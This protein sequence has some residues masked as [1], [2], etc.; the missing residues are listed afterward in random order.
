MATARTVPNPAAAIVQQSIGPMKAALAQ[1]A[2]VRRMMA[3]AGVGGATAGQRIARGFTAARDAAT[4]AATAT[5]NFLKGAAPRDAQGRFLARPK[6]LEGLSSMGGS[7]RDGIAQSLGQGLTSGLGGL[8]QAGASYAAKM[9][10]FKENTL[11][12]FKYITGSQSE[13][14]ALLTRADELARSMG[15]KTSDVAGSLRELMQGGFDEST[16]MALTAGMADLKAMNP[17]AN[18]EAIAAQIA[19]MKGSGKVL[20]EDLKPILNAGLNDDKFYEVLREQ[21]GE[22]DQ[23]KLKKMMSSGKVTADQGITAILETMRRQG[24]GGALGQ[25][26]ADRA[27]TTTGG[28]VDNAIG[29]FERLVTAVNSSPVG[30]MVAGLVN[31]VAQALDPTAG[32]AKILDVLNGVMSAVAMLRPYL[33]GIGAG[34]VKGFGDAFSTVREVMDLMGMLKGSSPDKDLVAGFT[35][36]AT[37]AGYVVVGIGVVIGAVAG[38]VNLI[39]S[40]FVTL[41]ENMRMIGTAITEGISAGIDSAKSGL[42]AKLTG[43]AEL[44]PASV[45]SLLGIHSPSRVF[46]ELGGYT[47]EGL[48][49]GIDQGAPMAQ[50][51]MVQAAQPPPAR[52]LPPPRFALPSAGAAASGAT[53]PGAAPS[54]TIE[55]LH[56]NVGP[57]KDMA[58]LLAKA[59]PQVREMIAAIWADM[60]LEQGAQT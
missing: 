7:I 39:I 13:A 23:A 40:A 11:F 60:M 43:L 14:S 10:S 59:R 37:A 56:I 33:E 52:A 29:M 16:S 6:W 41:P 18:V 25:V 3:Q 30:T 51:A 4:R 8:L 9:A 54:L 31:S 2:M 15:G 32:G 12:S 26:A 42:I 5:K 49:Q 24:G 47:V 46:A 19:Q 22:K 55:E 44:L 50:Q 21:T 45:R 1:V 57:V 36:I 34:F 38:L 58:D 17:T 53:A 35:A 20:M 48:A 28:A 27:A